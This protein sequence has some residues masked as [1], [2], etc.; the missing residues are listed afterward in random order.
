MAFV[1]ND[2]EED[3]ENP[4]AVGI[5][6]FFL[7][8]EKKETGEY[9]VH[10]LNEFVEKIKGIQKIVKLQKSM[11]GAGGKLALKEILKELRDESK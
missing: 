10:D 8:R 5:H 11:C 4:S 9:V 1:G 3:Y 2:Y 6:A 7:D